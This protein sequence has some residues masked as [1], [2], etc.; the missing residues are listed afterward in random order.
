MCFWL[1]KVIGW[2]GVSLYGARGIFFGL[3]LPAIS[4]EDQKTAELVLMVHYWAAMLLLAVVAVHVVA[5]FYHHF[6]RGDGVLRRMLPGL[7]RR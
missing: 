7:R 2:Y 4:A 1:P 3:S 6:I 5:A